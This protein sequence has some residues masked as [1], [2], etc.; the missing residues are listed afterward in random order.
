MNS[1][2]KIPQ[3]PDL[4]PYGLGSNYFTGTGVQK[5]PLLRGDADPFEIYQMM[6]QQSGARAGG[7]K[8]EQDA[9]LALRKSIYAPGS[10]YTDKSGALNKFDNTFSGSGAR[11]STT[12][13]ASQI[14]AGGPMNQVYNT[15][16]GIKNGGMDLWNP[17]GLPVI[18]YSSYSKSL[19]TVPTQ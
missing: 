16:G 19:P 1:S 2:L 6:Q 18:P 17:K 4:T 10:L 8:E 9:D 7:T 13:N 5:N 11:V 14:G 3:I 12:V 15:L